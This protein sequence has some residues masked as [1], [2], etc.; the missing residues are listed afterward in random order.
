[1]SKKNEKKS[2]EPKTIEVP[3]EVAEEEV[4]KA[5]GFW[6]IL[7]FYRLRIA[8][9]LL[10]TGFLLFTLQVLGASAAANPGNIFSWMLVRDLAEYNTEIERRNETPDSSEQNPLP[11]TDAH[12]L[13]DPVEGFAERFATYSESLIFPE[14]LVALPAE[15]R[16]LPAHY[17][18][19]AGGQPMA[20]EGPAADLRYFR[21]K[22]EAEAAAVLLRGQV[23]SA[24]SVTG[25]S[26]LGP[27]PY[28]AAEGPQQV[29]LPEGPRFDL[30]PL[31]DDFSALQGF[32][33]SAVESIE[34]NAYLLVPPGDS[35]VADFAGAIKSFGD[36]L[37]SRYRE[38]SADGGMPEMVGTV[39]FT[40]Y[41]HDGVMYA[42][43]TAGELLFMVGGFLLIF[44]FFIKISKA[45]RR[46]KGFFINM[47]IDTCGLLR[48]HGKLYA[49]TVGL[50][51][52]FWLWGM[53]SS[54]LDLGG[55]QRWV[56]YF[57]AQFAGTSWPLGFAGQ[58]YASGNVIEAAAATFMVNFFWGTLFVLTLFSFI[59]I[60]SAFIVNALRGQ[61]IGLA[62]APTKLF[63]GQ[64][65]APHLLTIVLELQGYLI[66]GFVSILLPLALVRPQ[67]LGCESRLEALK[68]MA[69]W[70]LKV[71]PLVAIILGIAAVYEALEII[72]LRNIL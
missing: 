38:E 59:P 24:E 35:S 47:M 64:S 19:P 33:V 30:V 21:I 42:A 7:A 48:T 32:V 44:H 36:R 56:Q 58:A 26:Y 8:I 11:A 71:L 54:Y 69:L 66:A 49:M 53:A 5:R 20:L 51:L 45:R 2:A 12:Y 72:L 1:M 3:A 23:G 10:V 62:L 63:M 65:M 22:L 46:E 29:V 17:I 55:Q 34:P 27:F 68:K 18:V 25:T 60:G 61:V 15:V 39:G 50:F 43:A 16:E 28:F 67:Q 70:Q 40:D 31:P 4:G 13:G 57:T 37:L 41:R 14:T 52:A 6:A 9:G